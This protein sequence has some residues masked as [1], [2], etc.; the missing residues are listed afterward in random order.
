MPK[1]SIVAPV[2]GVEKYIDQFLESIRTQT[3]TDFEVILVDDGSKDN[4]P[5]ILDEYAKTDSRAIVIHQENGGVSKARN[6][7]LEH[8]SGE[9]V[10]IVDS[11]DWLEPTALEELWKEAERTGADIIYGDWVSEGSDSSVRQNCF[12][13]AFVTSEKKTINVLQF[14]VNSNN[15]PVSVSCPEFPYIKSMGG[16]PWRGMFRFAVIRDNHV[17]YDPY[18]KGLGDDILFSLHLYQHV[19]KVAYIQKVIYHYRR[20]DS[21]YSHGFKSNYLETVDRIYEKQ[22]EFLKT[23]HKSGWSWNSYYMRVLIY[24]QQ[25]MARYFKNQD[26]PKSE[27]ERYAEFCKILKTQP[28]VDAVKKVSVKYMG[29]KKLKY[30]TLLLKYGMKRLYWAYFK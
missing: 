24:L 19:T 4:C 7:G 2:Y 3:M 20:L 15:T 5:K 23:Y 25:G 22:E 17:Q 11:D 1:I 10:Y 21:S 6:A 12:P 26:N 18:V 16:A 29:S 13:N 9:Y 14:A 8:V 28:Y 27:A 30:T